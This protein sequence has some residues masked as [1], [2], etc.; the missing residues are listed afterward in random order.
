MNKFNGSIKSYH[1]Q[2]ETNPDQLCQ[3]VDSELNFISEFRPWVYLVER[4]GRQHILKFSDLS[5]GHR[6]EPIDSEIELLEK[7]KAV[8]GITHLLEDY[9]ARGEQTGIYAILKEFFPGSELYHHDYD[10]ENYR[11]KEFGDRYQHISSLPQCFKSQV[12]KTVA[13]LHE[14]RIADL[15]LNGDNIILD[16]P[17]RE[18]K[19]VDFDDSTIFGR[20]KSAELKFERYKKIDRLGLDNLFK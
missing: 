16:L 1:P 11:T 3:T 6:R 8:P 13:Q 2:I 4:K 20:N 14:L 15:D 7:A 12:L 9:S 19:I 10:P 17:A 18:A 5:A